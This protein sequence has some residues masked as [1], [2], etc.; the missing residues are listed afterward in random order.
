MGRRDGTYFPYNFKHVMKDETSVSNGI[1]T[2]SWSPTCVA[3]RD[4]DATDDNKALRE[5]CT[6][7]GLDYDSLTRFMSN[8]TA[9]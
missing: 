3:L 9:Q 5:Y 4:F 8:G 7:S 1:R 2:V 6:K